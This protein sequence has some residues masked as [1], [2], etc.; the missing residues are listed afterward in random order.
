MRSL[1]SAQPDAATVNKLV[2]QFQDRDPAIREAAIRRLLT[3]PSI[4][5]AAVVKAFKEGNLSSRLAALELLQQWK[6]PV[7]QLDPWHPESLTEE[8]FRRVDAWVNQSQFQKLAD[9]PKELSEEQLTA[10]R[11]DIARMLKVDER[12]SIAIC[13]RLA[14]LGPGL[15]REVYKLLNQAVTDQDRQRLLVLR[16]R[17]VSPDSLVLRWPGGLVRLASTDPRQRQLAAEELANLAVTT[18][19][20]LLSELFSD[21]DPLVREI[22]LRGLQRIGGNEANAA[23]VKLLADPELNVRAAVLKQLEENPDA[24]MVPA[25]VAYLKTEKDQ[26]LIVHGICFLRECKRPEAMRCLMSLLSHESWQVRSEAAAGIG[27]MLADSDRYS[28]GGSEGDAE[29]KSQA[30]A[31]MAM[32]DLLEDEDAF[33]VAKAVEGLSR[34]DM[35][36]AVKPLVKAAKK[37]RQL[38][39]S[40]FA[41]M[42]SGSNMSQTAIPYLRT[43]SADKEPDIRA[44]AI[45][46]LCQAVSDDIDQEMTSALKDSESKVRI[47]AATALF[48]LFEQ[49][50]SK[51]WSKIING[52]SQ[53]GGEASI[54]QS[55]P[56]ESEGIIS[57]IFQ[58]FVGQSTQVPPPAPVTIGKSRDQPAAPPVT[59]GLTI[60]PVEPITDNSG[61]PSSDDGKNGNAAESK[62]TD[63]ELDPWDRWLENWHSGRQRPKWMNDTI[64]P[65]EKMLASESPK[66]RVV[67]A[68]AL[69]PLGKVDLALPVIDSAVRSNPE[70]MG[71]AQ[72]LLP[73]LPW[74]RR[75]QIFRRLNL[76]EQ[77]EENSLQLITIMGSVPD[78]RMIELF[79]ELLSDAKITNE[80]AS[81]IVEGLRRAYL[82]TRYYDS[83]NITASDRRALSEDANP[84]TT[85]GTEIQRL[86]ALVLLA[87]VDAEEAAAAA[88]RLADDQQLSA[89][90]RLDAFQ[91]S[92]V[93]RPKKEAVQASISA[94]RK[95]D[96]ERK[97]IALQYLVHG[98]NVLRSLKDGFNLYGAID[99]T[100]EVSYGEVKLIYPK[101]PG[102]VE[103]AQILP[104]VHDSDPE[105]AACAGYLLALLDEPLGMDALLKYWKAQPKKSGEWHRLVY[106]AIAVLDDP[107]YLPVLREIYS[108]LDEYEVREFY[109][110]VRIMTG[111]DILKFRKQIRD[112]QGISKLQ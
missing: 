66:E 48:K 27:K 9:Q 49:E 46:A 99:S 63:A 25:V 74:E 108:N 72:G 94:M 73:W 71:F 26:D 51:A 32:I 88:V 36:V 29:A 30:D 92:L 103:V 79:W 80:K 62:T 69:V 16:Y 44:A 3:Y 20:L 35:V 61:K 4:A 82:G 52:P 76:P 22:S 89:K 10:A 105:I 40:I 47:A 70:L 87:N 31:Y 101:P 60:A 102:G 53:S 91:V 43:F 56:L 59:N 107:K 104:L 84:R 112:E 18:D 24:E 65:L 19:E 64:E 83:S 78:R 23:L 38:A 54:S 12:E 41:T 100:S 17:L 93:V 50:R 7:E 96:N 6:A 14:G 110:T 111:P 67:A 15:L 33:V 28:T 11:S 75:L 58:Y 39:P 1:E 57:S 68:V 45:E 81:A 109:W 37:H 98:P 97:K 8:R 86:A 5:G 106:R 21:P 85:S 95:D 77:S 90:V 34:A 13:H 2:R 42:V 55:Q